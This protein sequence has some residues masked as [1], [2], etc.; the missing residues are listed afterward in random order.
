[1]LELR[2]TLVKG[3][4]ATVPGSA[5]NG[6]AKRRLCNNAHFAFEGVRSRVVL[7]LLEERGVLASAGSACHAGKASLS[8][9]MKAI[10]VSETSGTVR[11]TVSR[12]T[13]AQQIEMAIVALREAVEEAR[14]LEPVVVSA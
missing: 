13:T 2:N 5:L 3:V 7:E 4:L 10:G 12:E 6:D 11:C 14:R 1:M 8:Q 9:V